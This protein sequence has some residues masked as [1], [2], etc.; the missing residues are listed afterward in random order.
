MKKKKVK[1]VKDY[2]SNKTEDGM[3]EMDVIKAEAKKK[4]KKPTVDMYGIKIFDTEGNTAP[5]AFEKKK[6]KYK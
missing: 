6:L 5:S 3:T 4:K 1:Y 2:T